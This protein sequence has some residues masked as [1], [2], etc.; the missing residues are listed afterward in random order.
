MFAV[1]LRKEEETKESLDQ[2]IDFLVKQSSDHETLLDEFYK[3]F[4]RK[5][6]VWLFAPVTC[7]IFRTLNG[8]SKSI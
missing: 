4:R 3:T 1:N 8:F 6:L 7:R 5:K 2:V